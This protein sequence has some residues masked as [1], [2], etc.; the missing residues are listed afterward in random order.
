M[1]HVGS[2]GRP[3]HDN[4]V[5]YGLWFMFGVWLSKYLRMHLASASLVEDRNRFPLHFIWFT[6][7]LYVDAT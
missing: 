4:T 1:V 2:V 3:F 6:V 7:P 5:V